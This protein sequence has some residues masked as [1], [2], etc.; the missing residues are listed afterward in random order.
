MAESPPTPQLVLGPYYFGIVL[1][2]FLYGILL[3]QLIIYYQGY[4]TDRPWL[5]YFVFYLFFVETVNTGISLAMIYQ[6]LVGQFGTDG[7]MTFFPTLLPSQPLLETA[8]S[9]PVQFFYAWR[10]R[11]IMKSNW[12]PAL[13]LLA[14]FASIAGAFWTSISVVEAHT[15]LNKELVNHGA[16]TWTWSTF[17]SDV[18]ISIALITSLVRRKSGM[19]NTDDAINRIVRT[20]LQTGAITGIFSVLDV[21]LFVAVSN[22]TVNFT[23]DFGLPKLYSNALVSTLNAR[24]GLVQ[25]ALEQP[26]DNV[27]FWKEPGAGVST[28][29]SSGR[30]V[31][32]AGSAGSEVVFQTPNIYSRT[33]FIEMNSGGLDRDTAESGLYREPK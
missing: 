24:S 20:T 28:V 33:E 12:V 22:S 1:N 27:L 29:R 8:I 9:A 5:R 30:Q 17:G 32:S 25:V 11:V 13:I 3:L 2:T 21:V 23:F 26:Q 18:I 4:K 19:K 16:L 31:T 7:P 10:I 14:T 15:Y 6:P